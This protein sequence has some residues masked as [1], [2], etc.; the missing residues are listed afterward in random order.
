MCPCLAL[1]WY[2]AIWAGSPRLAAAG[3]GE[4][5][6]VIG[7]I[8]GSIISGA[9]SSFQSWWSGPSCFQIPQGQLAS[10]Q[11]S[12]Q[13]G[14]QEPAKE[15][16]TTT[17]STSPSFELDFWWWMRFAIILGFVF[18]ILLAGCCMVLLSRRFG[19]GLLSH[20]VPCLCSVDGTV[21]ALLDATS[22][23]KAEL[24]RAQVEFIKS[25]ERA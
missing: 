9:L 13:S 5:G 3:G 14:G 21:A 24:A 11:P 15:S 7:F 10:W 22:E 4:S 23:A 17:T 20:V 18:A 19:S 16:I 12:C 2:W 25:R 1:G 6:P 8:L